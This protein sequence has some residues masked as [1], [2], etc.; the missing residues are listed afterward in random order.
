M[1]SA[2]RAVERL[3]GVAWLC[4]GGT[5]KVLALL[6]ADDEEARVVG[7]AVRNALMGLPIGDI[8]IAT[9]AVPDEV[10]R[11]AKAAGIRTI[12]TGLDHG[13][14]TLLVDGHPYEVTTLR[15]DVETFGRKAKV[16]FGRNWARDAERRDFTINALSASVDGIVHD[17]VGGLDDLEARHV[18]FIGEASRRIAEDYLRILRFFRIHAAYGEGPVD[19]DGLRA[20]IMGRDGLATLSAERIRMEMVKLLLAQGAASALQEMGEAGLLLALLGGVTYHGPLRA[21][22]AAEKTLALA[23][24]PMRRL[25]ALAVVTIEDAERLTERLRL[26]NAEALQLDS[27]AHRWWRLGTLDETKA[28]IRL[29][30]LGPQRFRDRVLLGWARHG[31]NTEFWQNLATLATRWPVPVFP[32]KAADFMARGLQPGPALGDALN[33]AEQAWIDAG[34]P[35]GE[36]DLD[37]IAERIVGR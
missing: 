4:S 25:A 14:V 18:R 29:Y 21:M 15:E 31:G 30:K 24:D 5:A 7:G 6:N 13:T 37:A 2:V 32:L 8:D 9:T 12:P 11:R 28:R 20:C 33:R 35:A 1:S 22:I 23:P 3:H 34:F 27:M 10:V 19:C 16:A 17:Y 36:S 26:S